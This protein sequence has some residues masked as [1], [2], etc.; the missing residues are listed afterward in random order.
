MERNLPRTASVIHHRVRNWRATL[1]QGSIYLLAKWWNAPLQFLVALSVI[2]GVLSLMP[3]ISLD[4][5]GSRRPSSPMRTVFTVVN[6]GLLAV[7][8]VQVVCTIDHMTLANQIEFSN[9]SFVHTDRD[10][11]I[12]APSQR[13]TVPCDQGLEVVGL[14]TLS[15][16][17]TIHVRFRP[18]FVWWY[19]DVDFHMVADAADDGSWIWRPHPQ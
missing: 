1:K 8:D 19:R 9:V 4:A 3:R 6:D 2:S 10:S 5:S 16:E 14:R 11:T 17:M 15:A 7:H 18:D 13:M 12:L